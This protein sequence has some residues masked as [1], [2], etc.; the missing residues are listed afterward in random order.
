MVTL[1]S[2]SVS[3]SL[4]VLFSITLSRCFCPSVTLL[5]SITLRH[6]VFVYCH[7]PA[8]YNSVNILFLS[9]FTVLLSITLSSSCFLSIAT[10]LLFITLSSSCF[11]VRCHCPAFYYSSLSSFPAF[12]VMLWFFCFP[13]FVLLSVPQSSSVSFLLSVT[14]PL[15]CFLSLCHCSAFRCTIAFSLWV[16]SA[17][18]LLSCFLSEFF[19]SALVPLCFCPIIPYVPLLSKNKI[20][21][22]NSR[23]PPAFAL[24][25]HQTSSFCAS[26]FY[27]PIW[28]VLQVPYRQ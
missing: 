26:F 12:S 8:F 21:G 15:P 5:L 16:L 14:L 23:T 2:S 7:C 4:K 27:S 1:S 24:F 9:I 13:S 20:T 22:P 18:L 28:S 17:T 19:L 25:N 10:V 11:S 3:Q 6:P